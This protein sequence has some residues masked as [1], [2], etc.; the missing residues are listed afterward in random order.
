MWRHRMGPTRE[1][2][3]WRRR[4]PAWRSSHSSWRRRRSDRSRSHLWRRWRRH[5]SELLHRWRNA[6]VARLLRL[7]LP[8]GCLHLHRLVH[9]L[10]RWRTEL[11]DWSW[12]RNRTVCKGPWWHWSTDTA[13]LLWGGRRS[14][15]KQRVG[16]TSLGSRITS[17]KNSFCSLKWR[18]T[19]VT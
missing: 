18:T 2:L 9:V 14:A 1:L 15:R 19:S 3:R 11:W 7:A 4:P 5:A 12:R 16:P 13:I 8:R 6:R 10:L 17:S